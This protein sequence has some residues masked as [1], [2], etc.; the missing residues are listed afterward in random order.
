MAKKQKIDEKAVDYISENKEVLGLKYP[1]LFLVFQGMEIQGKFKS[2]YEA[3]DFAENEKM[4]KFV[5]W[6]FEYLPPHKKK[7]KIF[8]S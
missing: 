4:E 1:G 7:L 3:L 8:I 5:V 2:K 6:Y